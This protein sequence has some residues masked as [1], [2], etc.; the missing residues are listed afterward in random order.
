MQRILLAFLTLAFGTAAAQI[1]TNSH[2]KAQAPQ[3]K[4]AQAGQATPASA[5]SPAR[6]R[7]SVELAKFERADPGK[8][9]KQSTVGAARGSGE[10]FPLPLAP[11]EAA[12]YSATPVFSWSY[13]G[14]TRRFRLRLKRSR[15]QRTPARS[16]D[17]LR[18]QIS[19]SAPP[20][21]AGKPYFWTVQPESAASG[22]PS[23]AMVIAV[24][25]G[26]ERRKLDAT[27][28]GLSGTAIDVA[29]QRIQAFADAG[30]WYDAID[31]VN[32]TIAA[33]PNDADL[34]ELR[35]EVL[36]KVDAT[37][38]IAKRDLDRARELRGR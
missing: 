2:A 32:A 24:L 9:A 22:S 36:Q 14:P 29:L 27:L 11:N 33:N 7:V 6:M 21:E 13:P 8:M 3:P 4:P 38:A 17:R 30:V 34:L 25:G 10:R 15:W 31:A 18:I 26:A 20:L 23:P 5:P 1:S 16:G 35:G 28:N 19:V 12:A 37:R